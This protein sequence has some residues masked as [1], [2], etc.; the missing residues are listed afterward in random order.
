MQGGE[1]EQVM[2]QIEKKYPVAIVPL[3]IAGKTMKI[4]QLTDF[5]KYIE[6]I[7]EGS[8]AGAIELPYWAKIWDASLLLAYFLGKQPVIGGQRILEISA[9]MGVAG[10]YAALCGHDVTISDPNQEA[11]LFARAN[12]LLNN[13][14]R[15]MVRKLDWRHPDAMDQYDVIIGAEVMYDRQSYSELLQF[16][17]TAL[18]PQGVIFLSKNAQLPTSTF[19][20]EL[21]KYF[22][23]KQT[24]QNVSADGESQQIAL[25]AIRHKSG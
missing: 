14:P 24:V 6:D 9:G 21:T 2:A 3:K 20:S 13:C 19:F 5:E 16:L 8:H 23:F 4:L 22:K 12:A 7:I 10:L 18:K 25:Y 17:R 15:V 1:L 11:L